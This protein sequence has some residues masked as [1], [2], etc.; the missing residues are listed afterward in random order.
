MNYKLI[1]RS[2][3]KHWF[4]R[5]LRGKWLPDIATFRIS[6]CQLYQHVNLCVG[7][8]RTRP[9]QPWGPPSLSQWV[10]G[11]FP[12]DTAAGAWR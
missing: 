9:R 10:L 8:F 6:Q 5:H 11:L 12:V 3:S 7:I 1:K 2:H 4:I